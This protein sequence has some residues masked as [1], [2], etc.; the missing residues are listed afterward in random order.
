MLQIVDRGIAFDSQSLSRAEAMVGY[1]QSNDKVAADS[2]HLWR[3]LAWSGFVPVTGTIRA[4]FATGDLRLLNGDIRR[5]LTAYLTDQEYA[6]RQID[7]AAID[8]AQAAQLVREREEIYRRYGPRS[9]TTATRSTLDVERMRADP[10]LRAAYITGLIRLRFHRQRL[11]DFR[12]SVTGLQR[13]LDREQ[14][15]KTP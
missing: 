13:V 7:L 9:D 10:Q 3:G 8:V 5:S 2:I 12:E 4:L 14:G 15:A 11:R 1:L 6:E